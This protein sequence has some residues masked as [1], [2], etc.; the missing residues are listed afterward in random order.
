VTAALSATVDES[1][2]PA[3]RRVLSCLAREGY[4][5]H[6]DLGDEIKRH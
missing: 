3:E 5:S 1:K 4:L 2:P 6:Y